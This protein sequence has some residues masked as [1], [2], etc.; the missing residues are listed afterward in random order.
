MPVIIVAEPHPLLRLGILQ[1]LSTGLPDYPAKGVD[2]T[3]LSEVQMSQEDCLL[4]M[5][6]IGSND[7]IPRLTMAA[8]RAYQPKSILLLSES[9]RMP[10]LPRPFPAHVAGYVP[11]NAASEILLAAVRLVLAGGTCFPP[12][13]GQ[14][15]AMGLT[16]TA[17]AMGAAPTHRTLPADASMA[18]TSAAVVCDSTA[19]SESEKLGLTPRQYEVL[20]LLSRGYPMKTVGRLLNISVAT[21]KAHSEMLY[22]RLDV[23][24]RN[25]AVYEAISRGATLGWPNIS[26]AEQQ[27]GIKRRDEE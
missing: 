3:D 18:S 22:Q 12:T 6:S 13:Q 24:S 19:L 10:E 14:A 25:A 1:L 21:A 20:V 23:H 9:T 2:Y 7:D 16:T 27:S 26:T 17:I 4:L 8:E 5:L 15:P 11:K